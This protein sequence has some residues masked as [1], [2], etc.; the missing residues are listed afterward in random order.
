MNASELRIGNLLLDEKGRLCRVDSIN[1]NYFK[2]PAIKGAMTT[3]PNTAI[4][5]T[6]EWLI[7]LG[8][9]PV[10]MMFENVPIKQFNSTNR[11]FFL[12]KD[13]GKFYLYLFNDREEELFNEIKYVHQLQN[14]FFALT[15]KELII[16]N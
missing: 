8:F 9:E 16:N 6:E 11:K 13:I 10:S 7:K 14:L 5:L 12:T 2:A 3:L 1:C 15:G 4:E